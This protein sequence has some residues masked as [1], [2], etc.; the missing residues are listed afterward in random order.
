[1]S[2]ILL[3]DF[4]LVRIAKPE[5]W[6]DTHII[7]SLFSVRGHRDKTPG[8]NF[9]DTAPNAYWRFAEYHVDPDYDG[10]PRDDDVRGHRCHS[11]CCYA[12]AR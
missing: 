10:R 5:D 12:L 11:S 2:T 7:N 3:S 4:G 1:M 8:I 9:F 6:T